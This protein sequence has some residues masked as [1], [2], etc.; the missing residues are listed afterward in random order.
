MSTLA[1]E[2]EPR[3]VSARCTDDE[4]IVQ[5]ADGRVISVPLVWFPRLASSST[6]ARGNVIVIGD[7][8]GLHW[9][10]VDEDISVAGLLSGRASVE[11]VRPRA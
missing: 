10:A 1:V 7:G 5:L 4:L 11:H 2:I 8:E 6:H 9:P 3:A